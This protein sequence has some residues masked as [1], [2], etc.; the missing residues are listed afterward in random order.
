[1]EGSCRMG[2]PNK[3]SVQN[4]RKNKQVP[5]GRMLRA[6]EL[7]AGAGGLALGIEKASFR[8]HTVVER[9]ADCCR[10]IRA[11][12]HNGCPLLD[13]WRLF[14]GDVR[15]FDYSSIQSSIDLLAGGLPCQPFSVVGKHRGHLDQRDM[16][17][18]V[19]RAVRALKPR[20]IMV[21]NVR[22]LLRE[23]FSKYFEYVTLQLQRGFSVP[24]R[25][26]LW[27]A[28]KA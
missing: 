22:G 15:E 6:V 18:E 27:G 19:A 5:D 25:R 23:S 1:M 9:D 7:F 28:A 2:M 16:F 20:A 11:N 26:Q 3:E 10:T 17:P 14:A 12:Q 24:E 4:R 13:G 21:E 8:H